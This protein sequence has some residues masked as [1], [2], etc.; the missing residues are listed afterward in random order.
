MGGFGE[1]LPDARNRVWLDSRRKDRW[2][3]PLLHIEC[4]LRDNEFAMLDAMASDGKETL[5]AA[6]LTD[7]EARN[8]CS[9][10][11]G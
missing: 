9:R 10:H 1:M 11:R 6:G 3:I 4:T 8:E 7:V 2:G 5:E